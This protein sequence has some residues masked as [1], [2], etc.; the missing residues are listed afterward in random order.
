MQTYTVTVMNSAQAFVFLTLSAQYIESLRELYLT[1]DTPEFFRCDTP[2]HHTNFFKTACTIIGR[3]DGLI[4]G[5][6]VKI[7]RVNNTTITVVINHSKPPVAFA[8]LGLLMYGAFHSG[9]S[10]NTIGFVCKDVVSNDGD[11][12]KFGPVNFMKI[13]E[14]SREEDLVFTL[15]QEL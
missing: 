13:P 10:Y 5:T 14:D 12:Y 1:K 15:Y 11:R 6:D 8:Y 4:A 7:T 9:H 3:Y 2:S